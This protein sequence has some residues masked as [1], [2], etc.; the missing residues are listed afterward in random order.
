MKIHP[1]QAKLFHED[2]WAQGQTN[3]IKLIVTFHS[4]VNVLKNSS[5]NM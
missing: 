3:M 4:F 1:V 5:S 2:I